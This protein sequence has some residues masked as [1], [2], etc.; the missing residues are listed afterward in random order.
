M[1]WLPVVGDHGSE[2]YLLLSKRPYAT[3]IQYE[4][5]R[6]YERGFTL[7]ELLIV[8]VII[9]ALAVVVFVALNPVKRLQDARN[10]RRA[11]DV[12]T[13]L[14][15]IHEYTVDNQ[16]SLPAG[17]S[18]GMAETQLGTGGNAPACGDLY[19]GGCNVAVGKQCVD[20][21]TPLAPYLKT[22]PVDPLS[23]TVAETLYSVSVSTSNIVTVNAC[24]AEGINLIQNG[25]FEV[26]GAGWLY[27]WWLQVRAGAAATVGQDASTSVDGQYSAHINITQS[28][29]NWYVQLIENN[30]PLNAGQSYTAT[31]WAKASANRQMY[32]AVQNLAT[33]GS[34]TASLTTS[35]QQFSFPVT[36]TQA[37]PSPFLNFNVGDVTGDVWIDRVSLTAMN[38]ITASQ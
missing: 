1:V 14:T 23:G 3:I 17:L 19:T 31:F 16:G 26:A 35:W 32:V 33:Y 8:I 38:F 28:N 13:I 34:M 5:M 7:I 2:L 30:L 27:P 6:T 22:I 12:Q 4:S 11:S 37:D 15:A 24:G 18:S 10:T 36:L 20:L 25:S 29:L 9:A 21:S